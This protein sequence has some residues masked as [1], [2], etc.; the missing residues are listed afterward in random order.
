MKISAI[1]S[2][3]AKSPAVRMNFCAVARVRGVKRDRS[4]N[5]RQQPTTTGF[6]QD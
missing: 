5:E 3:E 2:G 4:G 1:E 6:L